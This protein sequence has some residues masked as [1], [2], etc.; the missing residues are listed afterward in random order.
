MSVSTRLLEMTSNI[1][2]TAR[3]IAGLIAADRGGQVT[4]KVAEKSVALAT[5][6]ERVINDVTDK[7]LMRIFERNSKPT[8]LIINF[9]F[10]TSPVIIIIIITFYYNFCK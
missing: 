8:S 1:P 7:T 5:I 3:A 6:H 10:C 9:Y 2:D 4:G